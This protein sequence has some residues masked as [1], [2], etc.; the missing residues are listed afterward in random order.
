MWTKDS[1]L[2]GETKNW[3][4]A[5]NYIEEMNKNKLINYGYTDW[6]L[7]NVNELQTLIND[8]GVNTIESKWLATQGFTNVQNFYWSSTSYA[9]DPNGAWFV[10]TSGDIRISSKSSRYSVWPVRA[11][12]ENLYP[13]QVWKT[14]QTIAY[15]PGDDG[16]LEKGVEWPSPRFTDKGDGTVI[17]NLTGLMW[18]KNPNT[19]GPEGCTSMVKKTW[20]QALDYVNC[21]NENR[22]LGYSDWRLPNRENFI[23]LSIFPNLIPLSLLETLLTVCWISISGQVLPVLIHQAIP[24]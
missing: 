18:T 23:V 16:D 9:Y 19:P 7:P 17:D 24:G 12:M 6:R 13:A 15:T 3:E 4:E 10:S 21:L 8:G 20:Q 14:G 2:P 22:Y 1:N 5:L 11:G